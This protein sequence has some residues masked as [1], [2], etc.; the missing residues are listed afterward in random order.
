[1]LNE[2]R[3]DLARRGRWRRAGEHAAL[4]SEQQRR[5]QLKARIKE[6]ER[7]GKLEEALRLTAELQATANARRERGGYDKFASQCASR[8]GVQ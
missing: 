6:A 8:R 4:A 5:E 7:A 3:R 2:R 1:M